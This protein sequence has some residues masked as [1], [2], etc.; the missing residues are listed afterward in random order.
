MAGRLLIALI[1]AV[2]VV[3]AGTVIYPF[4]L[5][6]SGS[7]KSNV[8]IAVLDPAPAFLWNESVLY[9][10]F[11]ESK[12]GGSLE[13][14]NCATG[15]ELLGWQEE[16]PYAYPPTVNDREVTAYAVFLAATEFPMH[17]FTIGHCWCNRNTF[18]FANSRRLTKALAAAYGNDLDRFNRENLMN[19]EVWIISP[20]EE[21]WEKP[22]FTLDDL[23]YMRVYR[24]FKYGRPRQEWDVTNMD[25]AFQQRFLKREYDDI[26]AY[27]SRHGTQFRS[28]GAVTLTRR[29]PSEPVARLDWVRF[30]CREVH[31]LFVTALPAIRPHY[32]AFLKAR[33]ATIDR[34]NVSYRTSYTGFDELPMPDSA[35]AQGAVLGDWR[36]FLDRSAM[37][38]DMI[39][40]LAQALAI[41]TPS[42]AWRAYLRNKFTSI[43]SLNAAFGTT[44][45]AFDQCA[46]PVRQYDF[47][48]FQRSKDAFR[49]D[50]IK[51]NYLKVLDYV[52]LH[53]R[54]I[55]N[56]AIYCS[57]AVLVA[58][59]VNPMAAYALSR[60]GLP[61]TYKILLFLLATMAFPAQ[62]TMIPS[63]LLL[64]KLDL[65]N[66]F[67]ALVLPG[68][69]NGYSIF[70]LKGFFDSLP[71]DLYEAATIDGAGE[72]TM[73][74]R[75]SMAM[76]KP[77]LAVIALGTFTAAYGA[78]MF[79]MI[80]CPKREMWT[81]MV[82]IYQLQ[83][84]GGGHQAVSYASLV[85]AS[86]PTLVVFLFCQKLIMRG[87]VVP[88]EK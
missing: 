54:G 68:A 61:A 72:W 38:K 84:Q 63:F 7:M 44:W 13:A 25:G 82:Y 37:R 65:L 73:F 35:A 46:M 16:L 53:G 28:F 51:R 60:F 77:I 75:I 67:F 39:E 59:I 34:L 69:A 78:F 88:T 45:S 66:T 10:K 79:A 30:V 49:W 32:R 2:L 3:G 4:L 29:A 48:V 27:N 56:S 85:I 31:A 24:D 21:A 42:T 41:N 17:W 1:Y 87:I 71:K 83:S 76:S 9:R 26:E 15:V 33:Y 74:W 22:W 8:D 55:L 36:I 57:L 62:V 11:L 5:M 52:A 86:I 70:L 81:L 14:V 40:P 12:Y 20:P 58:L 6:V 43:A 47:T 80:I 23:P 50:C 18:S 19:C 64:R